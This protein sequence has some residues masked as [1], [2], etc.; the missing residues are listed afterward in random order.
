MDTRV[1]N[2]NRG[3]PQAD[4][5]QQD[6]QLKNNQSGAEVSGHMASIHSNEIYLDDKTWRLLEGLGQEMTSI[7]GLVMALLELALSKEGEERRGYVE[8][9]RVLSTRGANSLKKFLWQWEGLRRPSRKVGTTDDTV[10]ALRL[11]RSTK[12]IK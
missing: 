6:Q 4:V 7:N 2:R 5:G 12:K 11:F 10:E 1:P 3:S 9:A 8:R